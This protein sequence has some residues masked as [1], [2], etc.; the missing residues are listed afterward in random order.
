MVLLTIFFFNLRNT[1]K[2]K[3]EK[4]QIYKLRKSNSRY[5]RHNRGRST[6]IR[7]NYKHVITYVFFFISNFRRVLKCSFFWV[8]PHYLV[9]TFPNFIDGIRRENNR[10]TTKNSTK[11]L[12]EGGGLSESASRRPAICLAIPVLAHR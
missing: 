7:L 11:E 3:R 8:I 5:K 9:L 6:K 4:I 12:T 10:K 2:K 1:P